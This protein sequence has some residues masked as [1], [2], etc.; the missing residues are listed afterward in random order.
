MSDHSF[1]SLTFHLALESRGPGLWRFNNTLLN[2]NEF[3]ESAK[4]EIQKAKKSSDPYSNDITKGVK[5]ELLLSNIR[6]HAIKRSKKIAFEKRLA[7]KDLYKSL[8]DLESILATSSSEETMQKYEDIKQRLDD[9]KME[10]GKAAIMK[11]QATWLEEGEKSTKYFFRTVQQRAAQKTIDTLQNDDGSYIYGHKNILRKC[12]EHFKRLYSSIP[13]HR[14]H[15][16]AFAPSESDP[17]LSEQEKLMCEGDIT[18]EECSNALTSMAR[19]KVAGISGF[20][21]EF[22]SCFWSEIGDIIV[23]YVNEAKNGQLFVTHRRGVITLIPKKGN[24]KILT[25]KRP[26]CLL[27]VIY[28]LIAKVIAIRMN[29]VIDKLVHRNQ[30]GFMKKRYIGE[31]TRLIADVIDYCEKDSIDGLLLAV[32]FKNAFDSIEHDFI[33]YTLEAFN[34]GPELIS[35]IKVLYNGALITICNNGFTSNWFECARG[36]FQ[37]SPLSGLLFILVGEMLANKIR[38][39]SSVQGITV[40]GI[41]VKLTMYAD[42]TTMFL[43]SSNSLL[44]ALCILEEFKMAS[45]LEL[46]KSKTKLMWLGPGR[47]KLDDIGGITAVSSVKILGIYH[48]ATKQCSEENIAPIIKKIK[49]V[50]NSWRQRQLTIKGR[51]TIAKALLI[52][53]LVYVASSIKIP[54]VD[55]Q[56]IQSLIM[57]FIWRGRP[58]KVAQSTLCLSIKQG[59]LKAPDVFKCYESLRLQWVKRMYTAEDSQWRILLQ[60]RIAEYQLE[61]LLRNRNSKIFMKKANI[62]DFYKIVIDRYN[63]LFVTDV[64]SAQQARTQSIWH[65]DA[66]KVGGKTVFLKHMYNAGKKIVDDITDINGSLM[67]YSSLK[68][69]YPQVRTN[70]LRFQS[71]K[72]AIPSEWKYLIRQEPRSLVS[73]E[74]KRCC[75][76]NVNSKKMCLRTVQNQHIYNALLV[77]RTPTAERKWKEEGFNLQC[78]ERV[79]EIPYKCTSSTKL[80]SLQY[81]V[82]HRYI[83]TRRFLCTRSIIGSKLCRTCFEVD[84]LQHFF[85]RCT[86]VKNIWDVVL[87]RLKSLFLLPSDFVSVNT[88]LFGYLESPSVVNLIILLCKQYIVSRKL[89][90]DL[91]SNLTVQGAI[92]TIINQFRIEEIV[93]KKANLHDQFLEKWDKVIDRNGTHI[94][95]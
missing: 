43:K 83:P 67:D 17:R 40:S 35:W 27:D 20:S 81:R 78:W 63:E 65:N 87:T 39:E 68:E 71:I 12:V 13:V 18:K 80:Q 53:Q 44:K 85:Y 64:R 84:D 22:F 29:K 48:S 37:G 77:K 23:D 36:T 60:A 32:D 91:P 8:N 52:S 14:E 50:T 41:E 11:S 4:L 66:V 16:E 59:G 51:I 15:M 82:L 42:D 25:N 95:E 6:V 49:N 73:N 45:G 74:D 70:F 89:W 86:D 26:I 1:V 7:E 79:Y 55:L 2:D 30:T 21:A 28:K 90:D 72:N 92:Q 31:N 88:V 75:L 10:R 57:K 5:I 56:M 69:K 34:F 24:Q 93:A 3:I 61:D 19:N 76:I 54:K 33:W 46:N 9:F 38:R 94:F 47:C 62:P 58:P